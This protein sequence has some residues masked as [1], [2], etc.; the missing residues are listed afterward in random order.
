MSPT[1]R[2][3]VTPLLLGLLTSWLAGC[4]GGSS[5]IA[6]ADPSARAIYATQGG[7]LGDMDGDGQPSVGDA[8]RILRIV[9]G[10]DPDDE[11][12]DANENGS[13]DVGDAIK[14]LR[15]VVGLDDWPIGGG[16]GAGAIAFVTQRD[17]NAEI[18]ATSAD[19][20]TQVRLTNTIYADEWEPAWSPDGNR[21]AYVSDR[22]GND[23][24]YVMNAD[25][26]NQT[27][28]TNTPEED[29][30]LPRWSP[31]GNRIAFESGPFD[32][33]DDICVMNADGSGR[34]RLT[35]GAGYYYDN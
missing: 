8:I 26:G 27:R 21:I 12:A 4:H 35:D 22:D 30:Y 24:I 3:C 33:Y 11:C 23:E 29:E 6:P 16:A 2:S 5:R 15:C 20:S 18:Y 17:G 9:V 28:L 1:F 31:D 34:M 25:G 7:L 19:G 32:G 10:L 14:V 13:T